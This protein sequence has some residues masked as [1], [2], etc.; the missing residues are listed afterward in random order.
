MN[1]PPPESP[2]PVTGLWENTLLCSPANPGLGVCA[3]DKLLGSSQSPLQAADTLVS[4]SARVFNQIIVGFTRLFQEYSPVVLGGCNVYPEITV[5]TALSLQ[6]R[7]N[8]KLN[9][10]G[11]GLHVFFL[12]GKW[13]RGTRSPFPLLTHR[14]LSCFLTGQL[15]SWV[16]LMHRR[17]LPL[18]H[19]RRVTIRL[20]SP[21]AQRPPLM[22]L[23]A[24][25]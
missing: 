9:A 10:R 2:P 22:F 5:L 23:R 14:R 20:E 12:T 11:S 16:S 21:T 19:P 18:D 7:V 13:V 17:T 6:A 15:T 8:V 4:L 24:S 1:R 25:A 3:T